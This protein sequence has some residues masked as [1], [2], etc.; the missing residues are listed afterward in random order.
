MGCGFLLNGRHVDIDPGAPHAMLLD[1][2]RSRG[3]T[4]SKEGCAEGECGSCSVL[5]VADEDGQSGYRAV[6]SCLMLL[7][8]A[9]D[10]E[11]YTV[12]S[13][14]NGGN[15]SDA[16]RAM[17]SAG[18]SQCGYCTPGFVVNL[19][20]EQYRRDRVG[21][22]DPHA[23]SGCLCRCTG[24]RPIRDA[25]LGIGPPPDGFFKDRL[26][27]PPAR[28]DAVAGERFAR[29]TT[30][31]EAV[32]WLASHPTAK[33]VAGCTDS[34]VEFNLRHA[35]WPALLS[36]EAIA[37]LHQFNESDAEVRIGAALPLTDI[38]RR[39][40]KAP[41]VVHEW[42]TLFASP[43]IRHRATL[44][45]NLATASPIG[46]SA[47]L[48][49]AW[50]A[51][52][53]LAGPGGRRVVPLTSFFTGYRKTVLGS[54]EIIVAVSLPKP[55]AD[56]RFYKVAKRRL[57]DISTVSAAMSVSI[58]PDSRVQHAR[59]AFGGVAAMPLRVVE[60]EAAAQ[61]QPWNARSVER[62]Q[63]AIEQSLSPLGDHRGSKAYREHVSRTL[64]ERFWLE[65]TT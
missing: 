12:E 10:R 59:F 36:V 64:V 63:Q 55:L 60:A 19:F 51:A 23:L 25:A 45:G 35:R 13:L 24:Y 26:D 27:R 18:G 40:V 39:W 29:P 34:G 16:Q 15:L 2:L 38:G 62:V 7:P 1:I 3:L 5:M 48:L 4:G 52:V 32:A 61:G 57:D 54:A 11:I 14:A 8:T 44:G 9:A 17:A 41:A 50:D 21:P 56:V 20:A 37:E 58:G 47:P 42:L 53:H 43:P 65:T 28:L 33:I 49:L 46:D 22:C 6:N 31:D 30:V